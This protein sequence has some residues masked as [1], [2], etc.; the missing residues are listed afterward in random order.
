MMRQEHAVASTVILG[1]FI[2][3]A[4]FA[5]LYAKNHDITGRAST[6]TTVFIINSTPITC[7]FDVGAGYNI[8]SL[9]CL[10]TATVINVTRGANVTAIYEYTPGQVDKWKVY[11]P[12]LPSWVVSDLYYMSRRPGYIAIM[13]SSANN[14]L[15]GSKVLSTSI[16]LGAGWNLVGFP[17]SN[18]SNITLSIGALNISI[19]NITAYDKPSE[20]FFSYPGGG[21]VYFVPGQGYWINATT[22]ITWTVSG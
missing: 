12:N 11:N 13:V 17:S 9:P 15:E 4:A 16:N 14:T 8:I 1:S 6:D 20:T 22:G 18:A 19:T 3:L 2:V 7:N 21:L 10:T 5:A